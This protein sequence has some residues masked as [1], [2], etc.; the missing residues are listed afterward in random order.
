GG[1]TTPTTPTT[2]T[3]SGQASGS[4]TVTVSAVATL[5]ITP[6]TTPPSA[7]LGASFKFTVTVPAQNSCAV[8][9]VTVNWGD[10]SQQSL[11]AVTGEANVSHVYVTDG[12]YTEM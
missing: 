6:P 11:G 12:T 5:V 4:V 3:S 1:G 2:P 8:R 9:E 10:G 7:G